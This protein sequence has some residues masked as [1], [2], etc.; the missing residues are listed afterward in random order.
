LPPA[1]GRL[2]RRLAQGAAERQ[3]ARIRQQTMEQ[4]KRVEQSLAFAG[5]GE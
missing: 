3:N 5:R 1:L 2:L 4:D